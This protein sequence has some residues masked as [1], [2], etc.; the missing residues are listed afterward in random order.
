MDRFL[1]GIGIG[2]LLCAVL[3][4]VLTWLDFAGGIIASQPAVWLDIGVTIIAVLSLG[5]SRLPLGEKKARALGATF[6]IVGLATTLS[7]VPV[8]AVTCMCGEDTSTAQVAP[9]AVSCNPVAPASCAVTLVNSGSASTPVASCA[10]SFDG[11]TTGSVSPS[12]PADAYVIVP[13]AGSVRVTCTM[14]SSVS[15]TPGTPLTGSFRLGNGAIVSF[16]GTWS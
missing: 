14:P 6:L 1:A 11:G 12:D 7:A 5:L 9:S 4:S 3:M 13:A 15:G 16:T 10:L 2:L 8:I